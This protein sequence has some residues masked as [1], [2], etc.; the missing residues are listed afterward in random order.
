M[1]AEGET[2]PVATLV[3]DDDELPDTVLVAV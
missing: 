1:D 2:V 3:R